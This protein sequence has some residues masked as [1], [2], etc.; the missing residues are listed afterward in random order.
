MITYSN[1]SGI[2]TIGTSNLV[3]WDNNLAGFDIFSIGDRMLQDADTTNN[4]H[5]SPSP[6][7]LTKLHNHTPFQLT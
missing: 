3:L 4:L 1:G 5:N 6:H 2:H 7:V